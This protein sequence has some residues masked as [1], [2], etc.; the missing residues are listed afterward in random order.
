MSPA[1]PSGRC[2]PSPDEFSFTCCNCRARHSCLIDGFNSSKRS[3][4]WGGMHSVSSCCVDFLSVGFFISSCS[5]CSGFFCAFV[6]L[7]TTVLGLRKD[8]IL[9]N[10]VCEEGG[11]HTG[12]VRRVFGVLQGPTHGQCGSGQDL[13]AVKYRVQQYV[14]Y[15]FS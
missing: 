5:A 3:F 2:N 11:V 10:C 7:R 8:L 6:I 14:E 13:H 1:E 15:I 9:W 4:L 12:C